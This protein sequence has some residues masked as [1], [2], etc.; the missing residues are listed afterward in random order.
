VSHGEVPRK[1]DAIFVF[2]LGNDADEIGRDFL[3]LIRVL[4]VFKQ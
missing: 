3:D 2:K 1:A 4:H